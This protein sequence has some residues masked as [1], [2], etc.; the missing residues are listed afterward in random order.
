MSK[1]IEEATDKVQDAYAALKMAKEEAAKILD[2][3]N[4]KVENILKVAT[5]D[6]KE[7]QKAR[8][9]AI[10]AFNSK[11]GPYSTV[12]TGEKARKDYLEISQLFNDL[13]NSFWKF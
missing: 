3:S 12:Y 9:D 10:V 2:E 6:L 13:F 1:A 5:D 8:T 4:E 7:A 11:F